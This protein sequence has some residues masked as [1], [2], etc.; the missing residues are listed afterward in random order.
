MIKLKK[1]LKMVSPS[2]SSLED[3]EDQV[4]LI[5]AI[6]GYLDFYIDIKTLRVVSFHEVDD[7][8]DSSLKSGQ[9]FVL[10][11]DK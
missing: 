1:V 3:C 9:S 10:I 4:A 5:T 7:K 2:L 6:P 11:E 8:D